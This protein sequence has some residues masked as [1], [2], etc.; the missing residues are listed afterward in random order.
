MIEKKLGEDNL[1]VENKRCKY[2]DHITARLY[3]C[4]N[5][6]ECK[7]KAITFNRIYCGKYLRT[8]KDDRNK[9]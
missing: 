7:D 9:I 6:N 1:N 3:H 2:A 5:P 8:N 4:T